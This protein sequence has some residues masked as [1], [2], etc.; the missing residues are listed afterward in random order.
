MHR[1]D[2]KP[3]HDDMIRRHYMPGTRRRPD[4]TPRLTAAELGE[5]FGVS[6]KTI[7]ARAKYLGISQPQGRVTRNQQWQI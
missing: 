6:A 1:Y 3:L 5:L 2:W 4:G 7:N